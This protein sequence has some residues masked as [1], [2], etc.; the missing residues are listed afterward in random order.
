[1]E[2][3]KI[4][5]IS[6]WQAF[7]WVGK[8]ES[9][10]GAAKALNLS[11]PVLSKKV[12][13]LEELLNTRLFTRTTRRVTPTNEARDL[14]PQIE[15]LLQDL[16]NIETQLEPALEIEGPIRLTCIPALAQR[17]LGK[18]IVKFQK[19]HPLIRFDIHLSDS[20]VDIVEAQMDVAIRGQRP[21][22]AQFVYRKL[23]PNELVLCASPSYLEKNGYPTKIL[24][25]NKH[26][27]LS[28]SAYEN[29]SF[30]K[31][32]YKL[33]EFRGS[34]KIVNEN[35]FFLT[36]LA[37]Q[38][39]GIAVRSKWDVA[40]YLQSGKLV[41]VLEKFALEPFGDIYA[42]T[43]HRRLLTMRV[44]TFLDFLQQEAASWTKVN[45]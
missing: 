1:M 16:R 19:L 13:R 35:G 18:A 15:S 23:I 10:T 31:T 24:D 8:R 3:I 22:G 4:D 41:Q 36:E 30:I 25:L 38:N 45:K 32:P 17:Y 21:T 11:V 5:D 2:T 9:F 40:P 26:H 7:Y 27:L 34:Q 44:R 42:V 14:L 37:L 39:A 20:L 43:P 28:L 33:K 12:A 29:C 6:L